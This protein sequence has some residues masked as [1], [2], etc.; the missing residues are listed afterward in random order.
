MFWKRTN[1]VI[2][3]KLIRKKYKRTRKPRIIQIDRV[4][5]HNRQTKRHIWRELEAKLHSNRII[6]GGASGQA[7]VEAGDTAVR[8]VRGTA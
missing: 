2:F 5:L 3:C 7:P 6:F 8:R 4:H 1:Y